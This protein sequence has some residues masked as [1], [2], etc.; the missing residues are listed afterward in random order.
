MI[1]VTIGVGAMYGEMARLAAR[2]VQAATGLPVRILGEA[3]LGSHVDERHRR[4]W[5]AVACNCL[6]F[7]LFDLIPD[8]DI[9]YFDADL[10][11]LRPWDPRPFAGSRELLCVRDQWFLDFIQVEAACA[12]V[13]ADDYF[14]FGFFIAS[15][16]HHAA[17]LREVAAH[18]D[19]VD[20]LGL[21]LFEQT[22]A[23]IVLHGMRLPIRYLDRCYNFLGFAEDS[24]AAR[25]LPV[26][27]A[28]AILRRV[29]TREKSTTLEFLRRPP[30]PPPPAPAID[31]TL[32]AR[33]RGKTMSVRRARDAGHLVEL[34]S[35]QTIG[36][37]WSEDATYW[38][39]LANAGRSAVSLFSRDHRAC[40]LVLGTDGVFRGRAALLDRLPGER[41]GSPASPPGPWQ[42]K[43]P[44]HRLVGAVSRGMKRAV[45]RAGIRR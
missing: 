29:G 30:A 31:E 5:G 28:H 4:R 20:E 25:L 12:G 9:L 17:A 27:G 43:S 23:N 37:G 35:D 34:R 39:P 14:N 15:R 32:A 1:A 22:V 44:V 6:K 21:V 33:L 38:Y 7:A 10:V 36:A 26:L 8:D 40:E 19:L 16:A 18:L 2:R 42:G 13:A 24:E 11:F 41:R 3:E 45:R